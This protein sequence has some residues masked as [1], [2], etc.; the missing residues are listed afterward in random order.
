[1]LSAQSN[2]MKQVSDPGPATPAEAVKAPVNR[3]VLKAPSVKVRSRLPYRYVAKGVRRSYV[4]EPGGVRSD[5]DPEDVPGLLAKVSL[6]GGCCGDRTQGGD[7]Y[8]EL[9]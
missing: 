4:F 3:G 7:P 2:S 6:G 8:F 9:V 1:M 5:V